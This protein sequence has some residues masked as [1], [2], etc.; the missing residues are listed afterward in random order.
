VHK[1]SLL[2]AVA[3]L[4]FT[5]ERGGVEMFDAA[6]AGIDLVIGPEDDLS[7]PETFTLLKDESVEEPDGPITLEDVA[8]LEGCE[9]YVKGE[10]MLVREKEA[11]KR[12]GLR[13]AKA[14]LRQQHL[15]PVEWRGN[16]VLIFTGMIVRD[17]DGLRFVACACWD[18]DRWYLAWGWLDNYFD[19]GNRAMRVPR[20]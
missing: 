18:G 20:K 10:K 5:P 16:K 6:V 4:Y 9:S 19:S 7:L 15:I 1:T 13:A 3:N 17:R 11:G 2:E 8:V 12:A 14:L